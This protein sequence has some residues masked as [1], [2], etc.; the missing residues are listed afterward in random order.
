MITDHQIKK[1]VDSK[2]WEW[3]LYYRLI[4]FLTLHKLYADED[5][6]KKEFEKQV[7]DWWNLIPEWQ[8]ENVLKKLS[9]KVV[10]VLKDNWLI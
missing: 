5:A 9:S 4:E 8:R 3:L 1:F 10:K 2:P 6:S 7:I